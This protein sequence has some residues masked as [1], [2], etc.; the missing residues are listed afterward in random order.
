M[1]LCGQGVI[2]VAEFAKFE[3]AT[4]VQS[5]GSANVA[6]LY[7]QNTLHQPIGRIL[8]IIREAK[9]VFQTLTSYARAEGQFQ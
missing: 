8:R 1:R 3:L 6:S 5:Q 7:S 4:H 2:H 9:S